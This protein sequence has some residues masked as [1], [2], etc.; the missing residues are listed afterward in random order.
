VGGGKCESDNHSGR[1][2]AR[3]FERVAGGAAESTLS[4]Y[5]HGY[6]DDLSSKNFV[7][8]HAGSDDSE[9][10]QT[11]ETQLGTIFPPCHGAFYLA[12]DHFRRGT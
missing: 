2:C 12:V 11:A 7:R 10:V 8:P 9:A 3:D 4:G 1:L 6:G 5:E